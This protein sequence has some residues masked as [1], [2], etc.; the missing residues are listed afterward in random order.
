MNNTPAE[1]NQLI[2]QCIMDHFDLDYIG[3]FQAYQD[4]NPSDELIEIECARQMGFIYS[5]HEMHSKALANFLP[6]FDKRD[7]IEDF[8]FANLLICTLQSLTYLKR[9][10]EAK[11]LFEKYIDDKC[12]ENF[13]QME[14]MLVWFVEALNPTEPE[15]LKYNDKI[16][17]FMED[18][19]YISEKPLLQEKILEVRNVHI[20]AN[21]NFGKIC[22]D[23]HQT[24]ISET[25]VKLQNFILSDPPEYYLDLAKNFAAK[26]ESKRI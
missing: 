17:N 22:S 5:F 16:N 7:K 2:H 12:N 10:A 19:G 15:L 26:L 4:K 21:H 8:L 18:L 14:G 13:Y 1:L 20:K 3:K 23:S 11:T 9:L 25:L 24:N 6:L